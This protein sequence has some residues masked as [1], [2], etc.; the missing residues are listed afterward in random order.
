MSIVKQTCARRPSPYDTPPINK[1]VVVR[2]FLNNMAEIAM[3]LFNIRYVETRN[4]SELRIFIFHSSENPPQYAYGKCYLEDATP[5]GSCV[6]L[7]HVFPMC[8]K[9]KHTQPCHSVTFPS[10]KLQ[11]QDRQCTYHT[12]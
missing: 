11:K 9:F 8:W 4:N 10:L 5:S 3:S 6:Y 2:C 12:F 1:T 7:T